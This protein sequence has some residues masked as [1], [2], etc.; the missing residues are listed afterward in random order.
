[1]Y[2]DDSKPL[3]TYNLVAMGGTFDNLHPGHKRLLTA[4]S[5][6]CTGTLTIGV[7]S[8]AYLAKKKKSFGEMIEPLSTRVANVIQFLQTINPTLKV[9]AVGIDDGCGPTI[10]RSEFQAIVASSETLAG[11]R[12]I[13]AIRTEKQ[14][15]SALEIVIVARTDEDNLSSTTIRKWKFKQQQQQQQQ[16]QQPA[17]LPPSSSSGKM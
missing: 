8:D 6:V 15:W 11:C 3:P 7:T 12:Y 14:G 1:M 2:E 10:Q 13:N 17:Q 4:A 9:E 16:Q 5:H